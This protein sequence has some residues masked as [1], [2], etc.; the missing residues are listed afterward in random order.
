MRIVPFPTSDVPLR[1]G[2]AQAL[3]VGLSRKFP[4]RELRNGTYDNEISVEQ[5]RQRSTTQR[6]TPLAPPWVFR[7]TLPP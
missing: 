4:R 7:D 1:L 3:P 2:P 6:L 5:P